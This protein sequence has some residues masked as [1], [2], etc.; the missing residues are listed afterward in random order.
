MDDKVLRPKLD[1]DRER[2]KDLV[3]EALR[4]AH[5][6]VDGGF[7]YTKEAV[8][9]QLD[10]QLSCGLAAA[11]FRLALGSKWYPD[12]VMRVDPRRKEVML[13]SLYKKATGR[14]NRILR[15]LR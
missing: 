8:L 6:Y 9:E 14:V 3:S 11:T 7:V 12:L 2:L 5:E 4:M 13:V 1:V 15:A 10:K